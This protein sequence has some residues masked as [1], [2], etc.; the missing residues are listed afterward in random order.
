MT[1]RRLTPLKASRGT[2]IPPSVRALVKARDQGCVG[3]RVG[4]DRECFG[5][6]ELDHVR[7]SGG[8]GLKSSSSPDN[9][10]TLCGAH[11]YQKTLWGRKWRP[12]LISWIE[13]HS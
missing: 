4:M 2:Q 7:A 3:P 13:A 9:L 1:L 10:V 6:L 11:H 5:Q 12:V 8:L